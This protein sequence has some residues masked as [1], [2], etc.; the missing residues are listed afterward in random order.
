MNLALDALRAS[1]NACNGFPAADADDADIIAVV[2]DIVVATLA[3]SVVRRPRVGGRTFSLSSSSL[4]KRATTSKSS[5]C[6]LTPHR[7][8]IDRHRDG[9]RLF[10]VEPVVVVDPVVVVG[11]ETR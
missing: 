6:S 5:C 9:S 7:R 1:P 2:I 10:L 4:S 8:T 3:M 11:P